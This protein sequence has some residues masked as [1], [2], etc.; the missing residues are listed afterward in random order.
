MTAKKL[1]E[2]GGYTAAAI[3]V[4]F[5]IAAL[6]LGVNGRSEVRTDVKREQVVGEPDMNKTAIL[7]EAKQAGLPASILAT[8]PTCNVAGKAIDSG[9]RAKCF[10]SYM[11]I[12][13]LEATGG[14][15]YAQ[16]GRYLTKD[17]KDTSNAALAATDP[18]TG[19]PVANLKRDLWVTE[20]AIS[21]ALNTSFFAEQVS[22]FSI[23][24]AIAL[25]LSGLGFGILAFMTFRWLPAHE[26]RMATAETTVK[27]TPQTT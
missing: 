9:A 12:H 17:G 15:T 19:Q 23:V 10:A 21:T 25:L 5:G 14:K 27:V 20:L 1:F 24:V 6:V 7:A 26:A 13:T 18:K 3:L 16:L 22:L 8:L 4:A 11:R 2:V